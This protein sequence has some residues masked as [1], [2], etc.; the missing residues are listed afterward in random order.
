MGDRKSLFYKK[1]LKRY[2]LAQN[3]QQKQSKSDGRMTLNLFGDYFE[4][5]W[6]SAVCKFV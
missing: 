3:Q 1:W 6:D 4:Q 5:V 2:Q